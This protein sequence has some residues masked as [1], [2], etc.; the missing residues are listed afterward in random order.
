MYIQ[1]I[2]VIK[3]S[4]I[5]VRKLDYR[6]V[7]NRK[8]GR[9]VLIIKNIINLIVIPIFQKY[10]HRIFRCNKTASFSLN[11]ISGLAIL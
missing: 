2:F 3:R 4:S 6:L 9:L 7:N 5:D 11:I 1:R 8:Y 10:I